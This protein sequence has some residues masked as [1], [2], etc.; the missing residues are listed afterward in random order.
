MLCRSKFHAALSGCFVL[1]IILI[2]GS[3]SAG[4]PIK[5]V[6]H[7]S[8]ERTGG[9][10]V[11][12]S[13]TEGHNLYLRVYEG[14]N[15]S[16][17]E[18]EFMAGAQVRNIEFADLTQGTGFQRGYCT[19]TLDGGST[20]ASWKGEVKTTFA[21]DSSMVIHVEGKFMFTSGTGQFENI[22]GAGTYSGK[23]SS[24]KIH[25]IDWEGEYYIEE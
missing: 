1:A 4:E 3:L 25:S 9:D 5:V 11:V 8:Y 14:K 18:N 23:F 7:M 20:V 21:Q 12:V 17:G 24:G 13:G 6:G 15:S 19:M 22:K 10:S 16:K 2:A